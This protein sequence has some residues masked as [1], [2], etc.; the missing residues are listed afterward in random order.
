MLRRFGLICVLAAGSVFATS[1]ECSA[2]LGRQLKPIQNTGRF[3]GAGYGRGYHRCNP[4]HDTSYYQ[5]WNTKNSFLIS[6][7]PEY[8]ARFGYQHRT[9]MQLLQAGHSAFGGPAVG[10][11][12]QFNHSV[13]YGQSTTP[14]ADLNA[15]F[16]PYSNQNREKKDGNSGE[17]NTE[18]D[19]P[20]R[21]SEPEDQFEKE[22]D[23]LNDAGT[24]DDLRKELGPEKSAEPKTETKP[25]DAAVLSRDIF[26]NSSFSGN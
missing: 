26:L 6:Q 17:E 5:P 2:Q 16:Q 12:G 21:N 13:Y 3:L 8:L 20:P 9:P 1:G 19:A 15:D 11:H 7:S 25:N 14:A 10:G 18:F 22:A 24:F 4:G 23:A